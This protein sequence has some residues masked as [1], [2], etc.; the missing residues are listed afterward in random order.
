MIEIAS[1]SP[2][3]L[4]FASMMSNDACHIPVKFHDA[5][6]ALSLMDPAR[7]DT[8]EPGVLPSR[9]AAL[10]TSLIRHRV[11]GIVTLQALIFAVA[12]PL[13]YL[14]R[15][16]GAVP[17]ETMDVVISTLPIVVGLK[18]AVFLAM[19]CHRGW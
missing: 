11:V 19:G 16:D 13:S 5:H 9:A 4:R 18:L 14:I 2:R 1:S 10:L 12:Y 15:F 6:V 17:A 8:A 3:W 7:G